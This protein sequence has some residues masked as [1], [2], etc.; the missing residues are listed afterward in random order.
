MSPAARDYAAYGLRIRSGIVLPFAAAS[1]AG[2]PDVDIR[3]GRAPAALAASRF[4]RPTWEAAPGRFLMHVDGVAR[5]F[6]REGR[7]ITV[8]PAGDDAGARNAFL[9]GSALAACLK[10]RGIL[11]LHASAV[12][13]DAG[14]VL[15]AGHSGVG[16]STL[17]AALVERGYPM[18]ADD[19]TGIV[20]DG[21]G[22]T[23]AL[24]AFPWVRLWA[25][26]LQVLGWQGRTR[27]QECEGTEKYL[28]PVARFHNA[29]LPVRAVVVLTR[30]NRDGVE[31]E[32]APPTAAFQYLAQRVYRKLYA[33]GLGQEREQFRAI[34]ALI[35][36]VPVVMVRRPVGGVSVAQ[37]A[38]G[39]EDCLTERPP[40][41]ARRTA[42]SGHWGPVDGD[43]PSGEIRSMAPLDAVGAGR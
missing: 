11:T 25:D 27:E 40:P 37:V 2:E 7:E 28:T 31:I 29:P 13:T 33:R 36:G 14:A 18:L 24:P 41:P 20:A 12:A 5:Y 15:F 6:V 16:K 39:I 3:I 21:G 10:Q 35:H 26:A 22:A 43:G 42:P 4:R 32:T 30:H 34:A 1:P 23:L 9:L 19:V 8:E 38:D 17:L